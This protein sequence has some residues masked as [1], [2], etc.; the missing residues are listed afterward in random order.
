MTDEERIKSAIEEAENVAELVDRGRT[1][2]VETHGITVVYKR[3]EKTFHL[4][5]H[6]MTGIE[7][8]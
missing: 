5:V 7:G 6:D 2:H 3:G 8:A 4:V 1:H